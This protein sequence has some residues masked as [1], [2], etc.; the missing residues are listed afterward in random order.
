MVAAVVVVKVLL[1]PCGN[2]ISR[3]ALLLRGVATNDDDDV[4]A[5]HD[6]LEACDRNIKEVTPWNANAIHQL[7]CLL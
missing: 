1:L 5:S 3:L 4:S 7:S 2:L 6:P